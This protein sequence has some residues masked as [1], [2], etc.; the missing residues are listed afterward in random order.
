MHYFLPYLLYM[1]FYILYLIVL[2]FLLTLLLLLLRFLQL[3]QHQIY[4]LLQLFQQLMLLLYQLLLLLKFVMR[5]H[6]HRYLP[7]SILN[8]FL[9]ISSALSIKLN[10][11]NINTILG[12]KSNTPPISNYIKYKSYKYC[13]NYSMYSFAKNIIYISL[14]PCT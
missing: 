14:P 4:I 1:H 3:F 11:T 9:I 6:Q 12:I 5:Y 13:I 8:I 10:V 2:Q 7:P